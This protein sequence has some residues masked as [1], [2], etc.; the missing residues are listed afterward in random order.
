MEIDTASL[1]PFRESM[2]ASIL[3]EV[4]DAEAA[5]TRLSEAV[6]RK[7]TNKEMRDEYYTLLTQATAALN[8]VRGMAETSDFLRGFGGRSVGDR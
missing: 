8:K 2:S 7:V 6:Q 5:L 1:P 4:T 3:I